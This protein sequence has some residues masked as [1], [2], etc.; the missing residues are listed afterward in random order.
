MEGDFD[1]SGDDFSDDEY[2]DDEFLGNPCNEDDCEPTATPVVPPEKTPAANNV[3]TEG[4][5]AD[6]ET[7]TQTRPSGEP[8]AKKVTGWSSTSGAAPSASSH[9][10]YVNVNSP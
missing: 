5:G 4:D 1:F 6:R 10:A 2:A 9:I 3:N 7:L 8:I